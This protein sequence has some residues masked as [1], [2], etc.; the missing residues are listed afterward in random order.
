M[1]SICRLDTQKQ[2][3]KLP[4]KDLVSSI[5]SPENAFSLTNNHLDEKR[6][7]IDSASWFKS[8]LCDN[9]REEQDKIDA[10][11]AV[12]AF[13]ALNFESIKFNLKAPTKNSIGKSNF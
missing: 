12:F 5:R 1:F 2:P 3:S 13:K 7:D 4:N 9:L 10:M 8:Q 11:Q 6:D